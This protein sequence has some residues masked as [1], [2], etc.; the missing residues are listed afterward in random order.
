MIQF[1][2]NHSRS[3]ARWIA[4]VDHPRSHQREAMELGSD[5]HLRAL[6]I[7]ELEQRR[8]AMQNLIPVGTRFVVGLDILRKVAG[9]VKIIEA[10]GWLGGV[11]GMRN[12]L[13]SL[14]R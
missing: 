12:D 7:P 1:D 11:S 13:A 5:Q 10:V 2:P 4:L 14:L 6:P 3:Y 8:P 9:V